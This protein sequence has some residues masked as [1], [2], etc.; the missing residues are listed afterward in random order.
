[1]SINSATLR[2]FSSESLVLE[3]L[4]RDVSDLTEDLQCIVLFKLG[5]NLYKR[6]KEESLAFVGL[7]TKMTNF[8]NNPETFVRSEDRVL[9]VIKFL[10]G[11][12]GKNLE[13]FPIDS[14]SSVKKK[15]HI[16]ESSRK[17]NFE[18]A[19]KSYE[20]L[21]KLVN[22]NCV[23]P[24]ALSEK[25][26][27]RSKI[28]SRTAIELGSLGGSYKTFSSVNIKTEIPDNM[29]CHV[30]VIDNAQKGRHK[31]QKKQRLKLHQKAEV[32]VHTNVI[33]VTSDLLAEST[34][35]QNQENMPCNFEEHPL[36]NKMDISQ[37]EELIEILQDKMNKCDEIIDII[38]NKWFTE[39]LE[40]IK[41]GS[42]VSSLQKTFEIN[43]PDKIVEYYCSKCHYKTTY[44][45]D[46]ENV[47]PSCSEN[48]TFCRRGESS[49]DKYGFICDPKDVTVD[50]QEPLSYNPVGKNLVSICEELRTK[51][52]D[53]DVVQCIVS[54]ALINVGLIRIKRQAMCETHGEIF[55]LWDH[56]KT[57]EHNTPDC[58]WGRPLENVIGFEGQSHELMNMILNYNRYKT[59]S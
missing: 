55:P 54:D 57:E 47:C 58:I 32:A 24:L 3:L 25:I 26:A 11:L 53:G 56:Q 34:M 8:E 33:S 52:P 15:V 39:V 30:K 48:P 2:D 41:T 20:C 10:E 40:D 18:L 12:T 29:K 16:P 9:P 42:G 35:L 49:F 37:Y 7:A 50:F 4:R 5:C 6:L 38:S 21:L 19:G 22:A 44:K 23:P 43:N 13:T 17:R 51:A 1:M 14:S 45:V 31:I 46:S 27:V 36:F 59:S 28:N